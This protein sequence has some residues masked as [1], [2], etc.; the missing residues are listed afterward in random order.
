MFLLA[1]SPVD[2]TEPSHAQ[3]SAV[4]VNGDGV[5]NRIR[6][7][8]V[9]IKVDKRPDIPFLAKSV[10]GVVVMGGVQADVPDR[11][12]RVNGF[13]FPEGDD[14]ADTVVASGIQETDMQGQV[15]TCLLYTSDAADD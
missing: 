2:H 13:K 6:A 8:P 12:I 7:S 9:G 15:N 4:R 5:W 1:V 11:D 10:S 14:G 3:G